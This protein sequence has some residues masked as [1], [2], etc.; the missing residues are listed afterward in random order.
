M[1]NL[2]AEFLEEDPEQGGFITEEAGQFLDPGWIGKGRHGT[3]PA[4]VPIHSEGAPDFPHVRVR[5]WVAAATQRI[6]P[7]LR[8]FLAYCL[9]FLK[10]DDASFHFMS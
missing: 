2:I 7:Q 1:G 9:H 10:V 5:R 3:L 6:G 4:S 8:D